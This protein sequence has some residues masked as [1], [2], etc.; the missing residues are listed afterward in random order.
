MTVT[1]RSFDKIAASS[2]GKEAVKFSQFKVGRLPKCCSN[3]S[4]NHRADIMTIGTKL[5]YSKAHLGKVNFF[6]SKKGRTLDSHMAKPAK[7]IVSKT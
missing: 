4:L 5:R 2:V 6:K 3:S 1:K 7:K